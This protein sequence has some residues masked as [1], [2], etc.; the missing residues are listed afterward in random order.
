MWVTLNYFNDK[1][2]TLKNKS[3]KCCSLIIT[4]YIHEI[5]TNRKLINLVICDVHFQ[6]SP[7]ILS[8]FASVSTIF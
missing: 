6:N 1:A 4:I 8:K 7:I 5:K 3:L 2:L